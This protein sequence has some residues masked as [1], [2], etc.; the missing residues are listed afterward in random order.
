MTI[1]QKRTDWNA[2]FLL[3]FVAFIGTIHHMC[4]SPGVWPYLQ[5]LDASAT[6][7]FY[8]LMRA[9]AS[10]GSVSSVL[11][12]GWIANKLLNTKGPMVASKALAVISC[13]VYL[14]A[15]L[16]S[17]GRRL[18]LLAFELLLGI[19]S[20]SSHIFRAHI[21]ACSTEK[22]RTKA[23][24]I[25]SLAP[26]IGMLL[27]P[28]GQLLFTKLGYPGVPLP[29]GFHLNLFTAPVWVAALVAAVGFFL[30]IFLFDGHMPVEKKKAKDQRR[31]SVIPDGELAEKPLIADELAA[32]DC[33]KMRA[34]S[35]NV[36]FDKIAV[37]VCFYTKMSL[38]LTILQFQTIGSPYGMTAFKFT[39]AEM[40][41]VG[42]I[43]VG[44]LG[45]CV[46]SWK[47]A[48]VF[49][50]LRKKLSERQAIGY[51]LVLMVAFYLLTYPWPFL[52]DTIGYRQE[53]SQV[54]ASGVDIQK[55]VQQTA[56]EDRRFLGCPQH[57]A[58]CGT[59]P[60]VNVYVYYGSAI[61]AFGV[62][63]P[64]ATLNLDILYS[65]VLGP[66]PQGTMQGWFMVC[67]E[68]LHIFGPVALSKVYTLTGPTYIWQG[69]LAILATNIAL[70]LYFYRRMISFTARPG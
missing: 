36:G 43:L 29:G 13:M 57:Y 56:N 21:A 34:A 52:P 19:A 12:S 8:G 62:A 41:I 46:L 40:V 64:L 18:A 27:T 31:A 45:I 6:E 4:I 48:Y 9:T 69:Q 60:R 53:P 11:L 24:A 20:G 63:F 23:I 67:G 70:W 49:T 33:D 32:V 37:F 1:E 10:A 15:E 51:A 59:T 61:L 14:C 38:G 26:S 66:I 25:T 55:S 42:S 47:L 5:K 39:S 3:T 68:V 54:N 7:N 44:A 35:M 58:W 16:L 65:K 28:V 22:D 50:S 30:L 17:S 2:V